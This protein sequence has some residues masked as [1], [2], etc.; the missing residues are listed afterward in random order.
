MKHK[1][2]IFGCWLC[3]LVTHSFAQTIE[4]SGTISYDRSGSQIT[5]GVA[6]VQNH[7]VT[8]SG[9]LSIQLWATANPYVSGTL[10]GYK[11]CEASLGT[12]SGGHYF[13]NVVRTVSFTEPPTG[14]YSIVLILAEWNGSAYGIVDKHNFGTR[15]TFGPIHYPPPVIFTQ[16]QSRTVS[17]GVS[18]TFSVAASSALP[19]TYQWQRDG[20]SIPGASGASYTIPNVQW[21]DAGNYAVIVGNAAGSV[22]SALAVLTVNAPPS[23]VGQPQDRMVTVGS[24]AIITAIVTG[25]SP[26]TFQWYLNGAPISGAT[27]SAYWLPTTQPADAGAYKVRVSNAFGS[28]ESSVAV[29]T[30]QN[31]PADQTG[32]LLV[33][34]GFELPGSAGLLLS[35]NATA[36]PGW[37]S[38]NNGAVNG[39]ADNRYVRAPYYGQAASE[40]SHFIYIDN[41]S[42][43]SA[44]LNGIYQDFATL[45][46][47]TYEVTFDAATEISYGFPAFLAVSVGDTVTNYTLP[48]ADAFPLP[49]SLPYAF[50]GWSTYSFTFTATGSVTRLQFFD[51]GVGFGPY[52]FPQ[53]QIG[54]AMDEQH[55]YTIAANDPRIRKFD[56]AGK[57]VETIGSLNDS[58]G[59]L[60]TQTGLATDGEYFYTIAAADHRMRR[61]DLTGNYLDTILNFNRAGTIDGNNTGIAVYQPPAAQTRLF[62]VNEG[63]STVREW[64]ASNGAFLSNAVTLTDA[65]S[66]ISINSDIEFDGQY[67]YAI[68]PVGPIIWKFDSAGRLLDHIPLSEGADN[69]P[70]TGNASPLLDKVRVSLVS[71]SLVV[72]VQP[73][74]RIALVGDNVVIE[75]KLRG[76]G[77]FYFQWW[78]KGRKLAG[79]TNASLSLP[80]IQLRA[81]GDYQVEVRN[82]VSVVRSDLVS[83][84]VVIPPTILSQPRNLTVREGKRV[85]F[86]V[87]VKGSKPFAYQWFKDG[88]AIPQATN[89]VLTFL[90]AAPSDAGSY[91]VRVSNAGAFQESIIA[92]LTVTP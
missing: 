5:L 79:Q 27:A 21:S 88:N 16:P 91:Y 11:L 81:R 48:S 30:I 68:A 29:L 61:F 3:L 85:N 4:M 24:S 86:R 67:F 38:V 53:S 26:R 72:N 71:T 43:A 6:R 14:T 37:V 23:I 2:F 15:E 39:Q 20:I 45:P 82:N 31:P 50:S 42:H 49:P 76:A 69:N 84:S 89:K 28:A 77:P 90:R 46:G 83:V 54:L 7:R 19:T 9:T 70:A 51:E 87:T 33:N 63:D 62:S 35:D 59:P 25:S 22:S 40:G 56:L 57:Y 32:N 34:G 60:S 1:S 36:V 58:L 52:L 41:H 55:F 13:Q 74:S 73:T 12:L 80:N 65:N 92:A 64:D 18:V 47:N 75:P 78:Y 44:T 8:T 10:A 66:L 17:P